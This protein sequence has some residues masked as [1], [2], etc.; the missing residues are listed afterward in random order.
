[1]LACQIAA[2]NTKCTHWRESDV[3]DRQTWTDEV[4]GHERIYR[5]LHYMRLTL[6]AKTRIF[7]KQD[8]VKQVL[9]EGSDKTSFENANVCVYN[10]L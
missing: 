8:C 4:G 2:E 10:T 5:V 9:R 7:T 3:D 6:F 1:M